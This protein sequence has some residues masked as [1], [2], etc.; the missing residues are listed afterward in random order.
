VTVYTDSFELKRVNLGK[1]VRKLS[2]LAGLQGEIDAF[3]LQARITRVPV[4]VVRVCVRDEDALPHSSNGKTHIQYVGTT[5]MIYVEPDANGNLVMRFE[6]PGAVEVFFNSV[7]VGAQGRNRQA[8]GK[9][10]IYIVEA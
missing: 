6:G 3:V 10:K 9:K 8:Q 1:G 5:P 2:E 4:E 7:K